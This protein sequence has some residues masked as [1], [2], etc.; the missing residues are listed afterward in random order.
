MKPRNIFI[1]LL[2]LFLVGGTIFFVFKKSQT[3][4]TNSSRAENQLSTN[5][6]NT[7][8]TKIV[9]FSGEVAN[10]QKF[11]KEIGNNLFFRLEPGGSS[12]TIAVGSKT[13]KISATDIGYEGYNNFA[14]VA[15]PPYRGINDTEI[16]GSDFRNSDN[17]GP[18]EGPKSVN[19]S[20]EVRVFYF[21]LN[22]AAYEKASEA[23]DKMLW[24]YSYSEQ[25]VNE[26]GAIHDNLSKGHGTLTIKD[27]KLNNLVIGKQAGIESMKFD[28]E[29]VFP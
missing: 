11:E 18:N 4:P 19:A 21:V 25:E 20:D 1:A 7:N 17:S 16:V 8:S 27:L 24:S 2:V 22:D 6:V 13:S 28:V 14:V 3:A 9:K 23:L 26:A 29:L 12:W 10:G 15:T 5:S